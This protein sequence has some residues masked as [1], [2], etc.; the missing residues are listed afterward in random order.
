[1]KSD[2]LPENNQPLV[3][4]TGRGLPDWVY[5]QAYTFSSLLCSFS[6]PSQPISFILKAS[7]TT[8]CSR[9]DIC[10]PGPGQAP[11]VNLFNP[12][13]ISSTPKP[14]HQHY[15]FVEEHHHPPGHSVVLNPACPPFP[16]EITCRLYI[17]STSLL[18]LRIFLLHWTFG[19]RVH[20]PEWLPPH[21][22]KSIFSAFLLSI[23][24]SASL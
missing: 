4:R 2:R 24:F 9:C 22:F 14:S 17:P 5:F 21:V 15:S 1:M 3:Y 12:E 7:I 13:L 23:S 20:T 18:F 10:S 11:Q 8:S 19:S 16:Q 6:W